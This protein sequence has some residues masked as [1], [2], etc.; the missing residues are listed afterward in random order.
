M[1]LSVSKALGE[2]NEEESLAFKFCENINMPLSY[3]IEI[4]FLTP[5]SI[6]GTVTNK[7]GVFE[8]EGKG[9]V[10]APM[11]CDKCLSPVKLDLDFDIFEEFSNTGNL[12]EQTEAFSKDIISLDAAVIKGI[13]LNIPMKVLFSEDC[14][15]LCQTCG[16]NLNEG[17]CGCKI[18]NIDPRFEKLRSLF[19]IN[20][21][22]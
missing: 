3:P 21:E 14:K 11:N 6:E 17:P 19:N 18:N 16:K 4:K 10:K 13:S 1:E 5:V 7:K 9:T 15:G 8:V 12:S 20:E 22:V 2:H